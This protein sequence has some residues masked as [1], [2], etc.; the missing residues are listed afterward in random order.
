MT[1]QSNTV[2]LIT[3]QLLEDYADGRLD[4]Q[5]E[6]RVEGLISQDHAQREKVFRMI[7]LREAIRADV[8]ARRHSETGGDLSSDGR[9][10]AP[11]A[12]CRA[13]T[14]AQGDDGIGRL[15]AGCRFHRSC[16]DAA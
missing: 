7:A 6:R 3:E 16:L 9:N 5:T 12:R 15:R 4:A 14:F 8:S 11:R 13:P 10:R 2:P 1:D